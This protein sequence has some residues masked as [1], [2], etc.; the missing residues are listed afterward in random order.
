MIATV[1]IK[2]VSRKWN[3]RTSM[4]ISSWSTTLLGELRVV[5]Y[6]GQTLMGDESWSRIYKLVY[7]F[8]LAFL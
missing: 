5:E 2:G 8:S 6:A 1:R 4:G 3:D 7:I